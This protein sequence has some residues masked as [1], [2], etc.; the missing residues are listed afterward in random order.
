MRHVNS[1]QNS[2]SSKKKRARLLKLQQRIATSGL[3]SSDD[4]SAD[5]GLRREF[6]KLAD[7]PNLTEIFNEVVGRLELRLQQIKAKKKSG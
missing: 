7:D 3:P 4:K 5:Q 2:A 1:P 6:R